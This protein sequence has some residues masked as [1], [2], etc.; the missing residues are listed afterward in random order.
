MLSKMGLKKSAVQVPPI[1]QDI[2]YAVQRGGL[3]EALGEPWQRRLRSVSLPV[4]RQLHARTRLSI[5]TK[6]G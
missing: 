1:L 6:P 3:A 2:F 4:N 5:V